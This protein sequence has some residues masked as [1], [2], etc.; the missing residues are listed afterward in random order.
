MPQSLDRWTPIL[1]GGAVGG[2]LSLIPPCCLLSCCCCFNGLYFMIGG[3][4]AGGMLARSAARSGITLPAEQGLLVGL[5][6]GLVAALM[7]VVVYGAFEIAAELSGWTPDFDFQGLSGLSPQLR[8]LIERMQALIEQQQAGQLPIAVRL[9]LSAAF[10]LGMGLVLGALGGLLGALIG[11]SAPGGRGGQ[12]PGGAPEPPAAPPE[13]PADSRLEPD[14]GWSVAS[15]PVDTRDVGE[16]RTGT[17]PYDPSSAWDRAREELEQPGEER[18]ADR[19][20]DEDDR[21]DDG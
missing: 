1:V 14:G 16:P 8:E 17:I 12:G 11:R 6:A 2:A 3:A 18:P 4:V 21:R 13:R 20:G 10:H 19:G 9:A 15:R 7:T 5:G